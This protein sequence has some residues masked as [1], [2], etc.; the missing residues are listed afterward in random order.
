M[1]ILL[2]KAHMVK[3][4]EFC[5]LFGVETISSLLGTC[6]HVLHDTVWSTVGGSYDS[7]AIDYDGAEKFLSPSE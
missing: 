1:P 7:G 5:H 2:F 4:I 6:S 3:H